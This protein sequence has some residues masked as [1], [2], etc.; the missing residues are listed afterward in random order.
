MEQI[1]LKATPRTVLG[2]AGSR[3]LRITGQVPAIAYGKGEKNLAL[4][5]GHNELRKAL[6][7]PK[8]R[9]ALVH[10]QLDSGSLPVM[11]RDFS[12]HPITRKLLH[13]DFI[14]VDV[15]APIEVEVPFRA[16]GKA[17][18]EADGGV[19]L[20]ASRTL[21]V[22]CLPPLIPA[23]FELD[24]TPLEMGDSFRVKDLMLPAGVVVLLPAEQRIVSVKA[25]RAAEEAA[26]AETAA[27]VAPAAGAPPAV[28]GKGAAAAPAK[29]AA[30]APA[31]GAA[32]APAK[33][34]A[35]AP[36]KGDKKK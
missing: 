28:A 18:G 36:A 20:V 10:L 23:G 2:S 1:T 29:G 31:K 13:A 24:V 15:N 11:V 22:R 14:T 8:G 17:K 12:V 19:V 33:G 5:V 7:S 27:A 25:P 4:M 30:A 6:G 32:A 26:V 34:A 3:R 16:I 35:A 9:N 21:H